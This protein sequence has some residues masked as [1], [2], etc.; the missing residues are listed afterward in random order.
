MGLT[1]RRPIVAGC[2]PLS[3]SSAICDFAM[4]DEEL[5]LL[6]E[7]GRA[8]RRGPLDPV[9]ACSAPPKRLAEE[10]R[11]LVPEPEDRNT[12]CVSH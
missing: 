9:R 4:E 5:P 6:A 12:G 8:G 2:L 7:E 10:G 1:A 11:L 3:T